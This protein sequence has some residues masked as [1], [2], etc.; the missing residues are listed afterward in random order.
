[1]WWKREGETWRGV[2]DVYKNMFG[3]FY[4]TIEVEHRGEVRAKIENVTF[5]MFN[6]RRVGFGSFAEAQAAVNDAWKEREEKML[7]WQETISKINAKLEAKRIKEMKE[8]MQE[9]G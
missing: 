4:I 6:W 2:L 7:E 5:P 3:S 1:M 8:K 9:I